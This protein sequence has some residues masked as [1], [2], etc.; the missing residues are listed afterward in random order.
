MSPDGTRIAYL[1]TRGLAVRTLDRLDVDVLDAADIGFFPFFS[2]DGKW[3]AGT[4]DGLSKVSVAGGPVIRLADTG[5]GA[6][7]AWAADGIVF[8]DVNGLFRVSA[9]GGTPERLPLGLLGPS[10][11][12]TFPEPLPGRRAVLFTVISTKSNTLGDSATSSTARIEA[13]DL[14]SGARTVVVRGGGRPRY[15]PSGHLLYASGEH[16]LAVRFDLARLTTVGEPVQLGD[17]SA[18]FAA[19][20][21]G[22]LMYG[23]GLGHGRRELVWVDR[24]GREQLVG[25]PIAEYAYPR[26]SPDGTRIA[27]DVPGPNRDVWMW[28]LK[29][30]V[31]ERF[32][33]DPTENV[34]PA[35]SP[36][37]RHLA[38]TSGLSGVPNMF[39]Q[40]TDGSGAAEQLLTSP[41]LQQAVSFASDGRLIFTESVPG[42]GREIKALALSTK[43]VEALVQAPGEQLSPEVSPDRR[44]IAYMSDETGQFEIYV[45]PYAAPDSGRW[46]VSAS[47]G[48][49]PLWSRDGRE[50]FYRDFGGALLSVPVA[51]GQVFVPGPSTRIIPP[52]RKYA[53]F[54]SAIGGRAYDVSPDGSRFL[55]IKNLDEGTEPSF[56]VV[57]NWLAEI[58]DRLR[59]R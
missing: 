59:P 27:L 24:R 29:R 33:S 28:N 36:D 30:Q 21:E 5:A 22:T 47:G 44:W 9:D 48:R 55:M 37:G 38:F 13:L 18:E 7:G 17:G 11:Q 2:P 46:K 42:R 26:I 12:V 14:D 35:W 34:L 4:L 19:S 45:R 51:A 41:L 54:G 56:V 53:G 8:A 15:L 25:A 39:L 3:I 57:Q 50:L 6:I 49:S 16:L 32:T 52:S 58:A 1:T 31:M 40:A 23:V 43:A 10:E 20:N